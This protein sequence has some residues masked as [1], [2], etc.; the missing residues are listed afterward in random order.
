MSFRRVAIAV[1]ASVATAA[2]NGDDDIASSTLPTTTD[3]TPATTEIT[4]TPSPP[5]TVSSST[6]PTTQAT[7]STSV[8][9]STDPTSP[10]TT[11]STAPPTTSDPDIDAAVQA[12]LDVIE[13]VELSFAASLA[14]RQDPLEDARVEAL[15]MYYAGNQLEGWRNIADRYREQN[16][17]LLVNPQ[18]PDMVL[19]E[20]AS[21]AVNGELEF[22]TLQVCEVLGGTLVEVGGNPDGSDRVIADDV[23]RTVVELDIVL[24]GD[25]WKV[26]S[27]REPLAEEQIATCE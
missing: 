16:L 12:R 3:A 2:C 8:P 17:R 5:T 26:Q 10:P 23:E 19:V 6:A 1:L 20:L 21:I 11:D 27:A 14:V 15:E 22:A 7:T 4:P 9:G 24:D 25:A 13:A 18:Q